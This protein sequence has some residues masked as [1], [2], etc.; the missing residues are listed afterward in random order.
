MHV[1][2][3]VELYSGYL[4]VEKDDYTF[5]YT[6]EP[7]SLNWG[8]FGFRMHLP[9][10]ALPP[11]VEVCPIHVKVSPPGPYQFPKGTELISGLYVIDF[12]ECLTNS[13]RVEVQHCAV[14]KQGDVQYP[15]T[16]VGCTQED[17]HKKQFEILDEGEFHQID[18]YGSIQLSR[19]SI[20]GVAA[21]QPESSRRYLAQLY[22]SKIG[23]HTWDAHFIIM[24]NL[25]ILLS[26]SSYFS[27]DTADIQIMWLLGSLIRRPP[28]LLFWKGKSGKKWSPV[29]QGGRRVEAVPDYKYMYN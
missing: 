21:Y 22:Y 19:S 20:V 7:K 24:W 15:L 9:S 28:L 8:K 25:N 29:M 6:G 11:D 13:L 23:I 4:Q 12:R 26:V 27:S 18:Q 2:N 17:P 1:N 5:S 10:N 3:T 14:T 16:F